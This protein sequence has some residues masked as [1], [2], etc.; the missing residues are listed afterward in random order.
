MDT[1]RISD[2]S[3]FKP[4]R[5]RIGPIRITMPKGRSWKK[6]ERDATR[7]RNKAMVASRHRH[8]PIAPLALADA[9]DNLKYKGVVMINEDRL[10]VMETERDAARDA[11]AARSAE[12]DAEKHVAQFQMDELRRKLADAEA[13]KAR[14][15]REVEELRRKVAVAVTPVRAVVPYTPAAPGDVARG[16][17]NIDDGLGTL[18]SSG[19]SGGGTGERILLGSAGGSGGGRDSCD[20]KSESQ[21][22]SV[23]STSAAPDGHKRPKRICQKNPPPRFSLGDVDA[24][25]ETRD[26]ND[27]DEEEGEKDEKKDEKASPERRRFKIPSSPGLETLATEAVEERR[28]SLSRTPS[29]V[30]PVGEVAGSNPSAVAKRRRG[31]PPGSKNKRK[32]IE[33]VE[34]FDVEGVDIVF[35]TTEEEEKE[36]AGNVGAPAPAPVETVHVVKRKRGRPKGSK[37]KTTL[38]R[39]R[40]L[41]ATDRDSETKDEKL[42]VAEK[43]TVA[44]EPGLTFAAAPA[45]GVVK[46]G[47]GRPKG[48]KNK[49]KEQN[50]RPDGRHATSVDEGESGDAVDAER[51]RKRRYTCKGCGER[52]H[53]VKTCGR[54]RM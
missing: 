49:K 44:E 7:A 51:A 22:R 37:N 42:T 31:R 19:G 43:R 5:T 1:F 39:E 54:V 3:R 15:A 29:P 53:S 14:L 40:L 45:A 26:S 48:S 6:A 21:S 12:L 9:E 8:D 32:A 52:G 25:F 36:A 4:H 13:A 27:D 16:A 20:G 23:P 41:D 38:M 17:A 28:R 10:T 50:F 46:R 24:R 33:P 30:L 34:D 11:A 47:R 2:S 35:E 18:G